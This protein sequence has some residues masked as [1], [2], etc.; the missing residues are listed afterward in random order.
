VVWWYTYE[1]L[2]APGIEF[3][4]CYTFGASS[5]EFVVVSEACC[6][7]GVEFVI[8]CVC[9][10]LRRRVRDAGGTL[11]LCCC[12][13]SFGV[14]RGPTASQNLQNG[15]GIA[16]SWRKPPA[17][18]V[19]RASFDLLGWGPVLTAP[20]DITHWG[21]GTLPRKWC[22]NLST[23]GTI[24]LQE[25]ECSPFCGSSILRSPDLRLYSCGC[26]SVGEGAVSA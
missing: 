19:G 7:S 15:L 4:V 20:S 14:V 23:Y 25:E 17:R 13:T 16:L 3:V 11:V 21:T 24:V 12:S 2:G 5:V 18:V 22:I 10:R 8:C 1:V 26:G 9:M 6:A